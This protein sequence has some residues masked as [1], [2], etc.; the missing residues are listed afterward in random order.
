MQG[1]LCA[2]SSGKR[3]NNI[4]PPARAK[5]V[6]RQDQNPS[7]R[8]F[9]GRTFA[10]FDEPVCTF[11][12]VVNGRV[13]CRSW[14]SSGTWKTATRAGKPPVSR[15]RTSVEVNFRPAGGLNALKD[16]TRYALCA[17][18]SSSRGPPRQPLRFL[19]SCGT[20]RLSRSQRSTG[21]RTCRSTRNTHHA[22]CSHIAENACR[23]FECVHGH[24]VRVA[25][26][27]R[28]G[29]FRPERL[30]D[31]REGVQRRPRP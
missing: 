18:Q 7:S 11:R 28:S 26:Q 9:I 2:D 17:T 22:A 4:C 31:L 20:P 21:S 13:P 25:A 5:D 12:A 16:E 10:V 30:R 6:R 14:R 19:G 24:K 1:Y 27:H 3:A 8:A 29:V 15:T 23:V